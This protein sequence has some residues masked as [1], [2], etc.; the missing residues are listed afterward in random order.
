[1]HRTL[2]RQCF[3]GRREIHAYADRCELALGDSEFNREDLE[4]LGF[5]RT[6]VLPVVPDLTH[7]DEPADWMVAHQFDD[8]WTNVLFVGRVIA[9][10]KIEDVIRCFHAYHTRFNPRSRLIIAGVFSLFERYFAGLTHLV[11]ELGLQHVH[12]AGHVSDAELIAYYE[13]A[14][15]FLCASEHEG[16]CVPLV[17]AFYK[18]VPVLA[19]AATAVPA[20]MDGA[21]VLFHTK[22]PDHVAAL[23]DAILSDPDLQEAIVDGQ[24]EAVERLQAR[25]FDGTLLGFVEQMLASPRTGTAHVAFDFW[26][27]F[28][29]LEQLEEIRR[30]RPSAYAALPEEPA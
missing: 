14:D 1:V 30:Y 17:E 13:T 8:D 5:P 23:M 6:A 28:D 15:L 4:S 27:Q 21:G 29:Q 22:D 26:Q 24:L 11:N 19:F 10:K 25:D 20:T 16:F 18:Q 7:L 12:F 3:R 2:A 9:N